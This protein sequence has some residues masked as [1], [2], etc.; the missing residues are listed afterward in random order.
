MMAVFWELPGLL[1]FNKDTD[2]FVWGVQ[3]FKAARALI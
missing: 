2:D 3:L 1:S